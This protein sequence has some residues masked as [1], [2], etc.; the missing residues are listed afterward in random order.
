MVIAECNVMVKLVGGSEQLDEAFVPHSL[1]ALTVLL[2]V[3]LVELLSGDGLAGDFLDLFNKTL[4]L[5]FEARINEFAAQ[6][7]VCFG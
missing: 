6:P 5:P 1:D 4:A 3:G 7:L 2:A